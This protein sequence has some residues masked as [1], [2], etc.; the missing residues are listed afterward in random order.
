MGDSPAEVRGRPRVGAQALESGAVEARRG[1]PER[2]GEAG[3]DMARERRHISRALPQG[4]DADRKDPEAIKALSTDG[5][6]CG[7]ESPDGARNI[8]RSD[9]SRRRRAR[10][11]RPWTPPEVVHPRDT[12]P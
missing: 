11:C 6:S 7:P 3:E 8:H 5:H 9:A 2:G 4:W 12:P 1:A 10:T